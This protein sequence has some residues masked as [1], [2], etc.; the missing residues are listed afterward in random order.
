MNYKTKDNYLPIEN[1]QSRHSNRTAILIVNSPKGYQYI[2]SVRFTPGALDF[3]HSM[4]IYGALTGFKNF[5]VWEITQCIRMWNYS[6]HT[7]SVKQQILFAHNG[8][9]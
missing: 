5:V 1:G 3:T 6:Q 9:S 8:A 2:C 7:V 4:S